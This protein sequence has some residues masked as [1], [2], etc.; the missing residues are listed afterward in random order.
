MTVTG[1]RRRL[2]KLNFVLALIAGW[3]MLFSALMVGAD[4]ALR[5]GFGMSL[6]G[7]DEISGYALAV[8]SSW[9]L[10]YGLYTQS[11]IRIDVVYRHLRV[12]IRAVLDAVA[13]IAV[14]VL[15][16]VLALYGGFVLI[17]SVEFGAR[18]NTPLRTPLWIPQSLWLAGLAVFTIS[19]LLML[20][21]VLLCLIRGNTEKAHEVGGVS[22]TPTIGQIGQ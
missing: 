11:H 5:G 17:E 19:S 15:A 7:A 12:Q 16:L 14:V 20:L 13:L 4:I 21:E 8:A 6:R 22:G 2:A 18:A 9:A 3:L 1:L 10:S